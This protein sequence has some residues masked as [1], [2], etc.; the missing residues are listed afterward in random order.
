MDARGGEGPR[1]LRRLEWTS[2]PV[3]LH[4]TGCRSQ[5]QPL[6]PRLTASLTFAPCP[7]LPA[8]SVTSSSS[9]ASPTH[10]ASASQDSGKPLAGAQGV[11]GK[12]HLLRGGD[13]ARH[14]P[15][16]AQRNPLSS[17]LGAHFVSTH[18]SLDSGEISMTTSFYGILIFFRETFETAFAHPFIIHP[19]P[20]WSKSISYYDQSVLL[21]H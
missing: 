15:S 4:S 16:S 9:A 2:P 21:F 20:L 6:D 17:H 8:G 13:C 7:R 19:F 11:S 5:G 1:D 12:A 14:G 18:S 10:T 3:C